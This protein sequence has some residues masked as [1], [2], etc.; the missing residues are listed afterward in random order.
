MQKNWLVATLD[1]LD[2]AAP[3]PSTLLGTPATTGMYLISAY[4]LVTQP[5]GSNS[6]LGP[7]TVAYTEAET[8]LIKT[9]TLGLNDGTGLVATTNVNNMI[10]ALL[11]GTIVICAASGTPVNVTVGYQSKGNT[12]MRYLVRFRSV[13]VTGLEAL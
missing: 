9:L 7:V 3:V 13:L 1:L 5:S 12:P 8:G 4:L 10:G 2:Q 6:T 11:T